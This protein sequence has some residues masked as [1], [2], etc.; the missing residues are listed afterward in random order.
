MASRKSDLHDLL[1]QSGIVN[2]GCRRAL[3]KSRIW[4]EIAVGI[5]VNDIGLT[6][7]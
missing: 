6:V 4:M 2:A 5:D 7:G 3:C 1:R